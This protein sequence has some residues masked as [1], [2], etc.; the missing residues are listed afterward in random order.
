MVAPIQVLPI[1]FDLSCYFVMISGPIINVGNHVEIAGMYVT[2]IK[3]INITPKKGSAA[4]TT[5][6]IGIPATPEVTNRFKPTGGVIIPISMFTT[7]M[8]PR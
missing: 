8:I 4:R 2:M 6:I 7:M 3:K 1:C 5:L